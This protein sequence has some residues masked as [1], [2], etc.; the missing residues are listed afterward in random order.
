VTNDL[1]AALDDGY[2]SHAVLDVFETEPLPPDSRFW[3]HPGVSVLPHISA[4]TDFDIAAEVIAG[5]I[6]HFRLTGKGP[7]QRR[8][9]VGLLTD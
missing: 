6:A 8:Y 1:P 4:P 7:R 3:H 2:L 9:R 5:N